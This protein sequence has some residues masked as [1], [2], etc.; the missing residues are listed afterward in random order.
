MVARDFGR[1]GQG[2]PA[3][4]QPPEEDGPRNFM[5][6]DTWGYYHPPTRGSEDAQ[7]P[8]APTEPAFPA[9]QPDDGHGPDTTLLLQGTPG[10]ATDI[11]SRG[12][13]VDTKPEINRANEPQ[14]KVEEVEEDPDVLYASSTPAA[15]LLGSS[16]ENEV[17][18]GSITAIAL[19]S[20]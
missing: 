11:R 6:E 2:G 4:S 18:V 17:C 7:V 19:E 1:D 8:L 3:A 5:R 15:L 12:S 14:V 10:A 20:I 13:P 9:D 16:D